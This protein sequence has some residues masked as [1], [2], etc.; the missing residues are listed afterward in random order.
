MYSSID[1][2]TRIANELLL[3]ENVAMCATEVVHKLHSAAL[4]KET[5]LYPGEGQAVI[6]GMA[7]IHLRDA[8]AELNTWSKQD[9][10]SKVL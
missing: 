4:S 3:L 1:T 2:R 8:L 7:W 6:S 5:T 9:V 10:Q